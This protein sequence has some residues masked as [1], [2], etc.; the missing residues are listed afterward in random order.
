MEKVIDNFK[1]KQLQKQIVSASCVEYP[2]CILVQNV[3]PSITEDAVE[4]YFESERKSG[5]GI[6]RE[7]QMDEKKNRAIVFFENWRGN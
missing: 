2:D 1:K 5:G 3:V 7:I 6:V 4:L